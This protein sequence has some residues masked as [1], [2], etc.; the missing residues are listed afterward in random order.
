MAPLLA[1]RTADEWLHDMLA[2]RIPCAP[3]NTLDQI[4]EDPNI[5]E[6]HMI[7]ETVHPVYGLARAPGNPVKVDGLIPGHATP[8]PL[9]GEHTAQVLA[10]ILSLD[11]EEIARL[12]Q[13]GV[14]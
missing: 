3:V 9:P 8:A 2:E 11:P 10:E 12:Q 1:S 5:Q 14:I 13:E 6:R 7:A 4:L